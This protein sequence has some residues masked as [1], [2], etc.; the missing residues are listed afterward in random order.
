M[1][2]RLYNLYFEEATNNFLR[3]VVGGQGKEQII[4]PILMKK[5][6]VCRRL[7]IIAFKSQYTPFWF[8]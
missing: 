1:E 5:V 6:G 2:R 3:G 4:S 7:V 8:R